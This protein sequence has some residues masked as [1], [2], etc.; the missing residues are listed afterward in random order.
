M[1]VGLLAAGV[2]LSN[3]PA[4]PASS[5]SSPT[6]DRDPS[7]EAAGT[8][9]TV[10]FRGRRLSYSVVDRMA[11]HA[12]DMVLGRIEDMLQPAPID[13]T[14][15]L[16]P[17][18]RAVSAV[19]SNYRW[20]GGV[21]PYLIDAAL[22]D[23]ETQKIREAIERWNSQTVI[24]L[25]NRTV[26]RDY[27]QFLAS[28]VGQCRADVG[29]RGGA[30]GVYVP[31]RG[32]SVDAYVHEIGH[33]LGLWHE[34]QREDRDNFVTVLED[35]L[36]L[37]QMHSYS[38]VHPVDGPY[39]Y[40][41]VMHY[42]LEANSIGP[43]TA[44][45]TVPPGMAVPFKAISF[46]DIDGVAR[47]YGQPPS[48]TVI[49]TNPPGL[50][51]VV[52]GIPQTAPVTVNWADGSVHTLEAPVSQVIDGSRFLFG[53]W[54]LGPERIR[55][56]VAGPDLTWVEA[57]FIVQHQVPHAVVP[58]GAGTVRLEPPS[59]DGY[60]TVRTPIQ[61]VAT[62]SPDSGYQFWQW[63]GTLWGHHGRASSPAR[64]RVDRPE[65][66]L[67]G[68]FTRRPLV[69]IESDLD[70]FLLHLDGD[71]R[72][73]PF[74]VAADV[75]D[76]SI[77]VAVDESRGV[78]NV[79]GRRYRFQSWSDGGAISH[80]VFLSPDTGTIK[81]NLDEQVRLTVLPSRPDGGTISADPPSQDGYYSKGSTVH[82]TA[83][84]NEGWEFAGW[85]GGAD[86][87]EPSVSV[88]ADRPIHMEAR[89]SRTRRLVAGTTQPVE[90]P[91]D[92]YTFNIFDEDL[93]YRVHVPRN[94]TQLQV[95]FESSTSGAEVDLFV[96]SGSDALR[97]N[98]GPDRS[99]PEF[100]ADHRSTL[101]GAGESVVIS[102][103]ST[104]P[105]V[106]GQAYFISLV[107]FGAFT[108][109][110]GSLVANVRTS[111]AGTPS[112][113]ASPRAFS[114]AAPFGSVPQAQTMRLR[115][116]GVG[117]VR[118]TVTSDSPWLAVL[119]AEGAIAPG[120]TSEITISPATGGLAPEV[121]RASLE[122]QLT[123]P[124]PEATGQGDQQYTRPI[125]VPVT[126]VIVDE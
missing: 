46:G 106:P 53:R 94:A 38:A 81:V 51:L 126:A 54:N 73:G 39:D 52:D 20:P 125:S 112:A 17:R 114:F 124:A 47:L 103:E 119:P 10:E 117:L 25:T 92:N 79:V 5:A 104:P 50:E 113:T 60:Y 109:V 87:F 16:I 97:W 86:S 65:L 68:L 6:V 37:S 44:M 111:A 4:A 19:D 45:E 2:L 98:Y 115:N 67:E 12:G 27:V 91:S 101:P 80:R 74:A 84:P 108:G 85:T 77:L 31:L 18:P 40:A 23:E 3:S 56:V 57:N 102:H 107:R 120:Q 13:A 62:P 1:R 69:R 7:P 72:Y 11:V 29:M 123:V 43:G 55:T 34:H 61:A 118:Y 58:E 8:V 48:G 88:V 96:T 64:L 36:D 9:A 100:R 122:I 42:S 33:A 14:D 22:P 32:C 70:P 116:D 28:A 75:P 110:D 66:A 15:A 89:F 105:L 95:E 78:P 93:G 71:F 26:E 49:S 59:P 24:S 76:R 82:L 83:H 90:Y 35:S 63:R 30:Q 121:Y 99:T 41:S 21:I